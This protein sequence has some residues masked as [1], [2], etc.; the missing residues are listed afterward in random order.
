MSWRTN[1]LTVVLRNAGRRAGLNKILAQWLHGSGYETRYDKGFSAELREGDDVWDIGANVGRYTRAFAL[2]VGPAGSVEAFEPSPVNF[3]RL[4]AAGLPTQVRLHRMALADA[5]GS[6]GFEQGSDD[7][8]AT[9]R[10][11]TD[12]PGLEHVPVCR[13]DS[14]ITAGTAVAPTALKIDVEGFELEVLEGFG[15]ALH[16]GAL[17]LIGIEVHFGILRERGKVDAPRQLERLLVD[18]GFRVRWPDSSHIIAVR[19][20]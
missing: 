8:G 17:R 19:R 11:R 12:I 7:L 4:V 15:R 6:L 3:R 16:D 20:V 1:P 14:L 13:A 10:L 2:R 9:S 5:D 18:A